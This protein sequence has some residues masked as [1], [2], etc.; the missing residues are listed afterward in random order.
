MS[1]CKNCG[2]DVRIPGHELCE[3]CLEG[4]VDAFEHGYDPGPEAG[5][6]ENWQRL[7]AEARRGK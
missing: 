4:K 5:D 2:G 3:A 7:L 6:Y 1:A